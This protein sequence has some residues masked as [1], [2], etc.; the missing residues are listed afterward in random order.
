MATTTT[1]PTIPAENLV[2]KTY[3]LGPGWGADAGKEHTIE[4]T[5]ARTSKGNDTHVAT[6]G[7]DERAHYSLITSCGLQ[8]GQ[9]VH[10]SVW[11]VAPTRITCEKC[12]GTKGKPAV[13]AARQETARLFEE[14]AARKAR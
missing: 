6:I 2:T 14:A 11:S 12:N 8:A 3:I 7:V 4:M 5:A 1:R 10:H 13:Q 9:R